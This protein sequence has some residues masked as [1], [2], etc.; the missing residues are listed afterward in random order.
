[1]ADPELKVLH[2]KTGKASKRTSEEAFSSESG[3]GFVPPSWPPLLT[4]GAGP[5]VKRQ[6]QKAESGE[7][8]NKALLNNA[9]QKI[10]K[11]GTGSFT[12][13]SVKYSTRDVQGG[14]Q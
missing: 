2:D 13:E 5:S 14:M 8:S 6:K 9:V 11:P 1:M 3:A 7:V 4:S 12:K 10:A